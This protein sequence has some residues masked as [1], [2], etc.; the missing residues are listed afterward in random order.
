MKK[1]VLA[2]LCGLMMVSF[3]NTSKAQNNVWVFVKTFEGVS[4][5]WRWRQELKDQYISELKFENN[6]SYKVEFSFTPYFVCDDG[7]EHT[8]SAQMDTIAPYGKKGGQWEGYLYYPCDG[9]RP[10][11]SGG[12]KNLT[13]KRVQ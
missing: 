10:P 6:N 3:V 12:Y 1:I 9:K 7:R 2:V 13:V 8:E 11:R 4:V 5:Y